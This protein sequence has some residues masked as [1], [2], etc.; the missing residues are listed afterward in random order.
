MTLEHFWFDLSCEA[1]HLESIKNLGYRWIIQL[2]DTMDKFELC[3]CSRESY[4]LS[5]PLLHLLVFCVLISH[6]RQEVI[7]SHKPHVVIF[8]AL[9]GMHSHEPHILLHGDL[10][11]SLGYTCLEVNQTVNGIFIQSQYLLYCHSEGVI[12]FLCEYLYNLEIN[13]AD[14]ELASTTLAHLSVECD[15]GVGEL[16]YEY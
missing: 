6:P 7:I 13:V 12:W 10:L 16:G 9:R 11:N 1:I 5:V 4:I 14:E 3:P 2:S 8:Q 15:N